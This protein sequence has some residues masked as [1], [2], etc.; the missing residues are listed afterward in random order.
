MKRNFLQ[1]CYKTCNAP[2]KQVKRT[3]YNYWKPKAEKFCLHY[4]K[5]LLSVTTMDFKGYGNIL[6]KEKKENY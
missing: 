2:N 6:A 1:I 3:K 5:S 4:Y